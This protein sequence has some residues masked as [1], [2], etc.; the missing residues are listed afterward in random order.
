MAQS[1][2]SSNFRNIRNFTASYKLGISLPQTPRTFYWY[3]SR[4]VLWW[5]I[6]FHIILRAKRTWNENAV[7]PPPITTVATMVVGGKSCKRRFTSYRDEALI[8]SNFF[9][10]LGSFF[11]MSWSKGGGWENLG[12]GRGWLEKKPEEGCNEKLF[13]PLLCTTFSWILK[14]VKALH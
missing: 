4:G 3:L 11:F 1:K 9:N 2:D 6:I 8:R 14:T 5:H 7:A 10:I 12:M 13:Q